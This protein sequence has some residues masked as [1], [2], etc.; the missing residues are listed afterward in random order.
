MCMPASLNACL[1][2]AHVFLFVSV[3]MCVL[4]RVLGACMLGGIG[5]RNRLRGNWTAGR[6]RGMGDGEGGQL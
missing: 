4:R 5:I 3:H 2:I 1:M 6:R